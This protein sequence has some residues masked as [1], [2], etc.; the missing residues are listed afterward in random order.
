[1]IQPKPQHLISQSIA[2][3]P[4]SRLSASTPSRTMYQL[5]GCQADLVN[6]YHS[7]TD[8]FNSCL[9]ETTGPTNGQTEIH[10]STEVI[11]EGMQES[12]QFICVRHGERGLQQQKTVLCH[13]E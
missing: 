3:G 13:K 1:M 5:N 10:V 7:A 2:Y 9:N 12:L 4:P 8:P 11:P 6:H